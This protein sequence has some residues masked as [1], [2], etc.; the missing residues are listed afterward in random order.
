MQLLQ[1]L[2]FIYLVL[3]S[4][5]KIKMKSSIFKS[6]KIEKIDSIIDKM[7]PVYIY[8]H[9]SIIF[10]DTIVVKKDNNI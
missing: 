10:H 3:F 2:L 6:I 8:Q 5:L 7:K 9:D 4:L 1:S